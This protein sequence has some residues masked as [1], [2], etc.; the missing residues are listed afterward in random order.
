MD[1]ST[2]RFHLCGWSGFEI[3]SVQQPAQVCGSCQAAGFGVHDQLLGFIGVQS[4]T[5]L[6]WF[7]VHRVSFPPPKGGI[8]GAE[9][10]LQVPV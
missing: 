1:F 10:S 4:Q 9:F 3:I 8:L 7:F 5:D 6:V 2:Q